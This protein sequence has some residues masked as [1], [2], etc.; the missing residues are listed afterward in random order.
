MDHQSHNQSMINKLLENQYK[1]MFN[2]FDAEN[3]EC[4]TLPQFQ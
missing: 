4:L 1:T 2:K 3:N